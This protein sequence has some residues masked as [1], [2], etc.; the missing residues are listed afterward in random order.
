MGFAHVLI[1]ASSNLRWWNSAEV[2]EILRVLGEAIEFH[3]LSL[4]LSPSFL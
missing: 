1:F 2:M 4:N 3:K